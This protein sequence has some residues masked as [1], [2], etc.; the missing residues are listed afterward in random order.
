MN[1][2]F[3]TA[4]GSALWWVYLLWLVSS[5]LLAWWFVWVVVTGI[6]GIQSDPSGHLIFSSTSATKT[7]YPFTLG[8]TALS[9]LGVAYYVYRGERG[10]WWSLPLSAL[11][12]LVSTIGM[13]NLYEQIFVNLADLAWRANWWWVYYGKSMD[14]FVFA[15]VG[16]SWVFAALPWWLNENRRAAQ[17]F[18]LVY[19]ATMVV[20]LLFGL[21]GVESG[22]ILAYALNTVSRFFSQATLIVLVAKPMPMVNVLRKIHLA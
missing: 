3:F 19:L 17:R 12:G 11:V 21:P 8:A 1:S 9:F 13:V 16:V 18:F 22:S 20:W 7:F 5:A 10:N 2:D 14:A 4:K 15:L 6:F